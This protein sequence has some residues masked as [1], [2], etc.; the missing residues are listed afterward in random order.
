MANAPVYPLLTNAPITEALIDIQVSFQSRPP[1]EQLQQVVQSVAGDYPLTEER[2]QQTF[3][4]K[5]G[6]EAESTQEKR[7]VQG[8]NVRSKDKLY[9]AQITP[10]RLTF[11]RLKPYLSWPDLRKRAEAV[12][13]CYRNTVRPDRVTRLGVR[14][15]NRFDLPDKPTDFG[16][17]F[18]KAIELPESLPQGLASF[19]V[20]MVIPE[21]DTQSVAVVHQVLEGP[22][23]GMPAAIIFDIDAYKMVDLPVDDGAVWATLESLRAYK[24]RIFFNSLTPQLIEQFK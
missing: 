16:L 22:R 5:F 2:F 10:D 8:F 12:W 21:P 15:I 1:I 19:F 14:Y 13:D 4:F 6:P 7:M 23:D 18:I 17:Y 3:S 20:K 11:S 24:N 9:V